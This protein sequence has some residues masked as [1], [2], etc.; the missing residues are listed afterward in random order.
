M[1]SNLTLPPLPPLLTT[2]TEIR[3]VIFS[4]LGK[5]AERQFS[6]VNK[7]F[8]LLAKNIW[9]NQPKIDNP[10]LN[11]LKDTYKK[12][13]G[14]KPALYEL[15]KE[16]KI[17][18]DQLNKKTGLVTRFLISCSQKNDVINRILKFITKIFPE[19][20]KKIEEYNTLIERKEDRNKILKIV[21]ELEILD[22]NISI[23]SFRST[24]LEQLINNGIQNLNER[25]KQLIIF[26]EP[27]ID[28]VGG[29]KNF[30]D[31]PLINFPKGLLNNPLSIILD[32]HPEEKVFR[33]IN[34]T[35][36]EPALIFQ[37]K[38]PNHSKPTYFLLYKTHSGEKISR[39]QQK[40]IGE[41][42]DLT[43]EDFHLEN[44]KFPEKIYQLFQECQKYQK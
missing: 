31:I 34:P 13:N 12:I 40:E 22:S 8:D 43:T 36:G 6:F 29:K 37:I 25:I 32:K 14:F 42:C 44:N 41:D 18:E 30:N 33:M 3:G 10:I 20:R 15:N 17:E 39:V 7:E 35:T 23:N 24:D 28:L 9:K 27:F 5:E 26:H 2:P 1:S 4:F 21:Q 38:Y 19:L 11:E 16:I